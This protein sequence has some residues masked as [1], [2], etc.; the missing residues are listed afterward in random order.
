MLNDSSNEEIKGIYMIDIGDWIKGRREY[1]KQKGQYGSKYPNF[2]IKYSHKI[3]WVNQKNN[4]FKIIADVIRDKDLIID[5]V[6]N[7]RIIKQN[8]LYSKTK[9]SGSKMFSKKWTDPTLTIN[10]LGWNKEQW[11]VSEINMLRKIERKIQNYNFCDDK[12]NKTVSGEL[13]TPGVNGLCYFPNTRK[14][15]SIEDVTLSSIDT[16]SDQKGFLRKIELCTSRDGA[17]PDC[18]MLNSSPRFNFK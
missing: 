14:Y 5:A 6:T 8:Q 10:F 16:L 9:D 3:T 11:G 18:E 2:A 13:W 17:M 12:M 15:D 4:G 7:L 1:N